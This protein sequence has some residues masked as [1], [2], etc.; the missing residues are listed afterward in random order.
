VYEAHGPRFEGRVALKVYRRATGIDLTA[1]DAFSREAARAS[2]LRHPHIAQVIESGALRDGTPFAMM[3]YLVGHTLEELLAGRGAFLATEMLPVVRG[4]ASALFAAHA[5]GLAHG[6]IRPDNIFVAEVAGYEHGFVKVLDFGAW[7][8]T[9]A[10]IARGQGLSPRET[11]YLAPEQ[12][13]NLGQNA[14]G[15]ADQ[16]A[17]AAIAYRMLV[18]SDPPAAS[19]GDRDSELTRQGAST[20]ASPLARR[21]PAVEAVVSKALSRQPEDRFESIA[22]FLRAFEEALAGAALISTPVPARIAPAPTPAATRPSGA[23]APIAPKW[24]REEHGSRADERRAPA[25]RPTPVQPRVH[26]RVQTPAH[27]PVVDRM[28]VTQQFFD[29]GE[30]QEAA[31]YNNAPFDPRS[32]SNSGLDF[33]SFDHVPRRRKPLVVAVLVTLAGAGILAW[34]AGVRPPEAWRRSALWQELHL[35]GKPSTVTASAPL[36][37]APATVTASAPLAAPELER[38]RAP[39]P[40]IEA[41][42]SPAGVAPAGTILP[43]GVAPAGTIVTT[44]PAA[45]PPTTTPPTAAPGT[46][47]AATAPRE[48]TPS[49]DAMAP[50]AADLPDAPATSPGA[51]AA[52]V[53]AGRTGISPSASPE[54]RPLAADELPPAAAATR[55]TA[56]PPPA[57]S[58]SSSPRASQVRSSPALRGYIWS[59]KL[60]TMVPAHRVAGPS[61]PWPPASE[62]PP[63]PPVQSPPTDSA[64]GPPPFNP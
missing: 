9:A 43:A 11:Q 39:H 42:P 62:S 40:A 29:E 50:A 21:A 17:L 20:A 26:T 63:P 19:H 51:A 15:P 46:P 35:P 37:G 7:R 8:L 27:P 28:T 60:H 59:P 64:L 14:T 23:P 13:A 1:V 36:P 2:G 22:L 44:A 5:A 55:L 12:L 18:G 16:F 61:E 52:A 48:T 4:T 10:Q 3:E 32:F 53:A 34:S 41:V 57:R 33:E 24:S 30:R 47:T 38:E 31:N 56:A 49:A 54:V 25:P 45:I 6:E 58:R